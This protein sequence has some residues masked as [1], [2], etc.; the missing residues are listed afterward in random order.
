MKLTVPVECYENNM[1]TASAVAKLGH[2]VIAT[3]QT[4]TLQLECIVTEV[5]S[6][7]GRGR[8]RQTFLCQ[9]SNTGC[10]QFVSGRFP[11]R[12]WKNHARNVVKLEFLQKGRN[13]SQ[14][15]SPFLKKINGLKFNSSW[16]RQNARLQTPFLNGRVLYDM[17][18]RTFPGQPIRGASGYGTAGLRKQHLKTNIKWHGVLKY[19]S[20]LRGS[21]TRTTLIHD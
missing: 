7:K 5:K 21:G 13:K 9:D 3:K 1:T 2:H 20:T 6:K 10:K 8:K 11:P 4:S 17:A 18:S 14:M 19:S 16:T 15:N 12:P